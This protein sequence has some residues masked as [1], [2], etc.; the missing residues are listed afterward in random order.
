MYSKAMQSMKQTD[1][2]TAEIFSEHSLI[3]LKTLH[4]TQIQ[5]VNIIKDNEVDET[6]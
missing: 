6:N 3:N 1:T 4:T 2:C 5:C